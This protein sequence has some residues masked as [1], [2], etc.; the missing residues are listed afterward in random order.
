MVA[1]SIS[2]L[3]KRKKQKHSQVWVASSHIHISLVCGRKPGESEENSGRP[4]KLCTERVQS[5]GKFYCVLLSYCEVS[6]LTTVS[7]CFPPGRQ[8]CS[9]LYY[10][11][12]KRREFSGKEKTLS[13]D[14]RDNL[15]KISNKSLYTESLPNH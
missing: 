6:V 15:P 2:G 13:T 7:L 8:K 4:C 12:E 11:E 3:T 10:K 1:K 9:F 14:T 5:A